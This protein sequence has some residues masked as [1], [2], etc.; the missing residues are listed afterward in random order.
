MFVSTLSGYLRKANVELEVGLYREAL[1]NFQ[2]ALRY[3]NEDNEEKRNNY[4]KFIN[5]SVRHTIS[6]MGRERAL[7][8]SIPWIGAA[9]GLVVGMALV[10]WDYINF[11]SSSY[12]HHPILKILLIG[13]CSGLFFQLATL[14]CYFKEQGKRQALQPPPEFETVQ[15]L[16]DKQNKKKV[17]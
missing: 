11:G 6:M 5:Q 16:N 4:E 3:L 2:L 15:I 13:L 7:S 1:K 8:V 17:D 12:I 14:K 9:F 10:A